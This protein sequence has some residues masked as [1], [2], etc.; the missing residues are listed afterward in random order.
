MRAEPPTIQRAFAPPLERSSDLS[1][2]LGIDVGAVN[3]LAAAAPSLYTQFDQPKK[4]G[5]FRTIR[6]PAK[7]L[8]VLQRRFYKVLAN[9][10]RYPRWMMGGVPRRSIFSHARPH[11]GKK[12]VATLDVK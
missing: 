8:R 3:A 11:V 12:M 9:R 1:A 7:S 4:S 2:V 6:P 10:V 5:G